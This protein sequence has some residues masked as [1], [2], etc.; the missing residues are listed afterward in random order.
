[1]LLLFCHCFAH[2]FFAFSFVSE[3]NPPDPQ[4]NSQMGAPEKPTGSR[5]SSGW[6]PAANIGAARDGY[7]LNEHP[8]QQTLVAD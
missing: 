7:R 4:S 8:A 2:Q 6:G 1:L 3:N 5:T